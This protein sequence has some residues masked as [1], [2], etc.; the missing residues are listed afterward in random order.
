MLANK[1]TRKIILLTAL[2]AVLLTAII[3]GAYHF[4]SISKSLS[5]DVYPRMLTLRDSIFYTDATS[6]AKNHRWDF[7]D[8]NYSISKKGIYKFTYPGNYLVRLT[9]NN[10]IVDTFYITV[11]DTA[12]IS[13][14]ND[15][16]L[17]I[18]GPSVA[19]QFENLVFRAVGKGATQ[20]RWW[21]G[22]NN[23]VDAKEPFMQYCYKQ[24]GD[25]TI[26][27]YADNSQYA[28][29]HNVTVLPSFKASEDSLTNVDDVYREYEN[30]FKIH[31]QEIAN[32]NNF[33]F[34]YYY[35]IKKY[36]CNNEKIPVKINSSKLNNFN[37]YCLGLQFD[38]DVTIQN[39]KVIP[40]EQLD[41]LKTIE[42]QQLK[43]L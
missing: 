32:G 17:K 13:T 15:S 38:K 33:N 30:D 14:I 11:K 1:N 28:I 3:E 8:G 16:L 39:V 5:A 27:L 10:S 37:N 18:E 26:L 35:L 24:P 29:R 20:Y 7:G 43:K 21:M 31:L 23:Y 12:K 9:V 42:V 22:E 4:F 36:L 6:F 41:C 19:M 2:L 25:Y 34:H 40:D